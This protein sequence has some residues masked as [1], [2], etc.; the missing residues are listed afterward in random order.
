MKNYLDKLFIVEGALLAFIGLLFFANPI[1]SLLNLTFLIGILIII[2]AIAKII[3][4]FKS[5]SKL[6]RLLASGIDIIFGLM[7]ILSPITSIE[8][9]LIFYGIWSLIRGLL[10]LLLLFQ[11]KGFGVNFK[12]FAALAAII[13]G[14][15]IILAPYMLIFVI[16]YIPYVIGMYFILVAAMEIYL[17]LQLRKL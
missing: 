14:F 5:S 9:M 13:I 15:I 16:P 7:L 3:R 11:T 8:M 17:G 2:S 6:Y 10:S 1:E 4:S 12:S